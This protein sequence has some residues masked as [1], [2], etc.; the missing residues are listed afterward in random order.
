MTKRQLLILGVLFLLIVLGGGAWL[1]FA[2]QPETATPADVAAEVIPADEWFTLGDPKAKVTLIEY[3]ALTCP[4]CALWNQEVMPLLKKN[5]IDNGKVFYV[6]RMF[7]RGEPDGLAEKMARCAPREKYFA[8]VDTIFSNQQ[9]WD[10]E[11]GVQ[12]GR[13][14][15][16]KLGEQMGLKT[17][18]INKCMDSP[19]DNA[20]INAVGQ[21]AITRYGLTG[22][23]TFVINGQALESGGLPYEDLAKKL[24]QAAH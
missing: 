21:E 12:D 23:P 11:F 8:M 14:Q 17:D 7:A 19:A 9:K 1:Y 13:A 2:N 15:L 5:Y 4:H 22:T 10:Y 18:Q 6:F 20:R 24:D 16:V 3:G